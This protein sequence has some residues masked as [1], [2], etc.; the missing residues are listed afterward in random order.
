L[1]AIVFIWQ[2]LPIRQVAE[3]PGAQLRRRSS[4]DSFVSLLMQTAFWW[5]YCCS[6]P[7]RYPQI[8]L[9]HV[10]LFSPPQ[11][12]S[13]ARC[14]HRRLQHVPNLIRVSTFC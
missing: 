9:N 13:A 12:I 5:R 2:T 3:N 8:F 4:I 7:F 6:I 10:F 1:G 11:F 14:S